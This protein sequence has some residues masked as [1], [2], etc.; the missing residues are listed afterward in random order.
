MPDPIHEQVIH[1]HTFPNGLTLL[2][3]PMRTVQSAAFSFLVPAGCVYEPEGACGTVAVLADLISRGAGE[4]DSRELLAALD[5]L[6]VQGGETPGLQFI[7]LSGATLAANLPASLD[8]YADILLRPHLPEDEFPA[9][10]AGIE[11]SLRANEDEPRQKL[12]PELRRRAYDKPWG[13]PPDGILEDLPNVNHAGVCRLYEQCVRPNGSIMGVAGNVEFEAIRDAVGRLFGDWQPKP[14]PTFPT[15][16][17]GPARDHLPHDSEQTHIG[18]AY[19]SV[20]LPDPDYYTAWAATVILGQGMSSRLFTEVR[21]KRGLCY[22]TYASY[23]GMKHDARVTCYAGSA[24]GR[25]QETLDV[26]CREIAH[27]QGGVTE[28]ELVRCRAMA[29]SSL[30]MQQESTRQRSWSLALNWHLRGRV[31]TLQEVKDEIDALTVRRIQDYL[32]AHPPREFTALTV[33][34]EPLNVP[35]ALG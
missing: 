30:V 18:L 34:P 17:G 8:L 22:S 3:E 10:L 9:A 23:N 24:N 7:T 6:G 28:D 21:E 25:A 4:M 14:D 13:R 2:V 26:M 27:L 11:Q 12:M 33:G 31:V 29:K 19:R 32:D 5:N 1:T 20:P 16:P 35:D 15:H